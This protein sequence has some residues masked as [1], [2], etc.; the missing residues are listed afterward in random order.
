MK[1]NVTYSISD[2]AKHFDVTTR[3]IRF[4]EDQGLLS[5]ERKNTVR[6]Y[7]DRDRV[8]LQLILRG[9]RLGFSLAEIKETLKL[10]DSTPDK[11]IQLEYVLNVINTH[12]KELLEKQKDIKRTLAD[13]KKVEQKIIKRLETLNNKQRSHS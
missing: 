2:L 5:P 6:I 9:K 11:K 3:T 13:M 7:N 8:R 4:Y 12:R 1:K 10:Y